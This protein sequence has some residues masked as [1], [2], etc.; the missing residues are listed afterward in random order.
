MAPTHLPL[1][2]QLPVL[3]KAE[4]KFAEDS[5]MEDSDGHTRRH[6][7]PHPAPVTLPACTHNCRPGA[8][9]C[10]PA[11]HRAYEGGNPRLLAWKAQHRLFTP[12]SPL[13]FGLCI[14]PGP[15]WEEK[16]EAVTP[17]QPLQSPTKPR[18]CQATCP[19]R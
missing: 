5:A 17:A 15:G 3:R 9:G 14:L 10:T 2:W 8:H 19:R 7:H 11:P 12:C 1:Y 18:L 6:T 13:L 4:G 16:L